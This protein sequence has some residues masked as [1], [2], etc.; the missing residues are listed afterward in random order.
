MASAAEAAARIIE[1]SA[2]GAIWLNRMSRLSVWRSPER[3]HE[4]SDCQRQATGALRQINEAYSA[5]ATGVFRALALARASA[6][7]RAL[8]TAASADSLRWNISSSSSSATA[9]GA[10]ARS[11]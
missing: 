9:T 3:P 2:K 5:A 10:R 4:P 8:A 1:S 6:C 7:A 11:V